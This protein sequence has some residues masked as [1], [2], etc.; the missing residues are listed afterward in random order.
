MDTYKK[1]VTVG[2]VFLLVL[3]KVGTG[4]C[5]DTES[6]CLRSGSNNKCIAKADLLGHLDL[7]A[8]TNP[9]F[10]LM[11]TTP[12][13]VITPKTGD[14]LMLSFLP[15]AVDAFGGESF[16]IALE[17]N[18]GLMML[19][20]QIAMSDLGFFEGEPTYAENLKLARILSRVN[21]SMVANRKT[22]DLDATQY[23]AG[24]SYNYDTKNPMI[25]NAEY[26]SCVSVDETKLLQISAKAAQHLQRLDRELVDI[27]IASGEELEAKRR[28]IKQKLAE[29]KE[30]KH[31]SIET[32]L[33]NEGVTFSDDNS[34]TIL[35]ND[36][37]EKTLPLEDGKKSD[38][39]LDAIDSALKTILEQRDQLH[40]RVTNC[41]EEVSKWNRD[42]F[43]AGLAVYRTDET[44]L[45]DPNGD[46]DNGDGDATGFGVWL[47]LAFETSFADTEGQLIVSAR[48]N[49]NLVQSR[50]DDSGVNVAHVD[51]WSMGGRYIQQLSSESQSK[52]FRMGDVRGFVEVAYF[53]EDSRSTD[54]SYWQAGL[55]AE[56]HLRDD[57]YFQFVFGDTFNSELDRSSY[58]SGQ[59]KWSLSK[60]P[61]Q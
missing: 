61:A 57:L 58:L 30:L 6:S 24:V 56:I 51:L 33:Q 1:R 14:E 35:L 40:D 15:S 22:G 26:R 3:L 13:N 23:G 54:D 55:G 39:I 34:V 7:A 18:P 29:L 41:A 46:N 60:V 27:G 11:G 31:S 21:L 12:E 10:T 50:A 43:A 36:G 44:R 49:E 28:T 4:F 8:P 42:V 32:V 45:L 17:L 19:P 9:L 47:S 25:N 20:K 59:F 38:D 53:D 16:A 48:Y 5:D 37:S 2:L 52:K